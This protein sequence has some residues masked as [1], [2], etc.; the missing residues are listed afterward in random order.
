MYWEDTGTAFTLG[1]SAPVVRRQL[2]GWL[3]THGF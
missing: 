1:R 3:S 2:S